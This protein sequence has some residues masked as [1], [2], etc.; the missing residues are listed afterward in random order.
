MAKSID[1]RIQPRA[2]LCITPP[3][4]SIVLS[5]LFVTLR[6]Y[7]ASNDID[8]VSIL[9]CAFERPPVEVDDPVT[10]RTIWTL[11]EM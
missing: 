10:S 2:S 11:I 3:Y 7:E 8:A 9:F 6:F 5:R 1:C 4:F